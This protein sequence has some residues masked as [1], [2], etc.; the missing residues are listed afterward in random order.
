VEEGKV[1]IE[2]IDN[3]TRLIL[4]AKYDLV[5]SMI[6]INIVMKT[7]QNRNFHKT[8]QSRKSTCCTIFSIFKTNNQSV[9][10]ENQDDCFNRTIAD[11]KR[12]YM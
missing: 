3:A 8:T 7:E 1:T 12:K 2:Q 4:N 11:A 9:S 6:R 5:C 10:F